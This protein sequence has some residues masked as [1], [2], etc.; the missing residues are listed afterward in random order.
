MKARIL[1]PAILVVACATHAPRSVS[2]VGPQGETFAGTL[3]Y[4]DAWR[5]RL[6]IPAG[7]G[8]DA[9]SGPFVV[10]PRKSE[11][12]SQATIVP[13][14]ATPSTYASDSSDLTATVKGS[15]GATLVCHVEVGRF[16]EQNG[17]CESAPADAPR[18]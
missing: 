18:R 11:P 2:L 6:E 13:A 14:G 15:R 4:Q 16:G 3:T 17:T 12:L 8:G 7:P 9:Y 5:G 10:V 1:L